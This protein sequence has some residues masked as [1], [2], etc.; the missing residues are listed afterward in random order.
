M[1]VIPATTAKPQQW[2]DNNFGKGTYADIL[3]GKKSVSM[4][5][6]DLFVNGEGDDVAYLYLNK[7]TGDYGPLAETTFTN[8]VEGSETPEINFGANLGTSLASVKEYRPVW[9]KKIEAKQY[10]RELPWLEVFEIIIMIHNFVNIAN[11]ANDISIIWPKPNFASVKEQAEI[12]VAFAGA[13]DKLKMRGIVTNE[14]V[15]DT[16]KA[17]DLFELMETFKA[18]QKVVENEQEKESPPADP[19]KNS[20]AGADETGKGDDSGSEDTVEPTD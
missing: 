12:L 16:L 15:Y 5:D 17:L 13:I 11:I 9:I 1:T 8:I 18:H 10:E 7:T 4:Q 2:I 3:A 6:R 14:E 20:D 19:E